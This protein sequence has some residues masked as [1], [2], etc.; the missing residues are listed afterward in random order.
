MGKKNRKINKRGGG[1]GGG[2]WTFIRH[3][4]VQVMKGS[5]L[6]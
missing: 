5:G 3:L 2:G 4:R 1:G 6:R